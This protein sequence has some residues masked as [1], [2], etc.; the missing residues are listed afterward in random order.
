MI[1]EKRH[2]YLRPGMVLVKITCYFLQK[3]IRLWNPVCMG[4]GVCMCIPTHRLSVLRFPL[5]NKLTTT[6]AGSEILHVKSIPC[7]GNILWVI[8]REKYHLYTHTHIHTQ[9]KKPKQYILYQTNLLKKIMLLKDEFL[10]HGLTDEFII[11][12]LG[13]PH[14][15]LKFIYMGYFCVCSNT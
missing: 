2:Q 8:F 15:L 11:T 7:W 6:L 13:S 12:V 3:S 5:I 14:P 1:A 9:P 4:M 10:I